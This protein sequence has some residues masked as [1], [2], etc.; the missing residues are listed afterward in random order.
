MK[1]A[2]FSILIILLFITGCREKE[3]FIPEITPNIEHNIV[4]SIKKNN[5]LLEIIPNKNN[6]FFIYKNGK[7]IRLNTKTFVKDAQYQ[8]MFG[9][10]SDIQVFNNII[11][12]NSSDNN[13]SLFD[14][15]KMDVIYSNNNIRF[16]KIKYL[17]GKRIIYLYKNDI[18]VFDYKKNKVLGSLSTKKNNLLNCFSYKNKLYV[19]TAT[20]I[21]EF[22]LNKNKFEIIKLKNKSKSE[23]LYD[24]GFLYYC[25]E[26]RYLIKYSMKNKTVLWANKLPAHSVQK[27]IKLN[28]HIL[29]MLKDFNLYFFNSNGTLYWWEKLGTTPFLKP[30]IS[31]EN[32]IV[33]LLPQKKPTIKF[34][35]I[36]SKK[37][38][39]YKLNIALSKFFIINK[40]LLGLSD[41]SINNVFNLIRIGNVY[42]VDVTILPATVLVKNKSIEFKFTPV[43]LIKPGYNIEIINSEKKKIY[44]LEIKPETKNSFIWFPQEEGDFRLSIEVKSENM[45]KILISKQF[46]VVDMKKLQNN[47]YY[48]ILSECDSVNYNEK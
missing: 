18:I 11:V 41:D 25:S 28:K 10:G 15:E 32:T 20:E 27:P 16:D 5:D 21:N 48:K 23:F 31:E 29:I 40:K 36:K 44:S 2:F 43:N 17:D 12:L 3:L 42:T 9:F 8:C 4:Y 34:F 39:I 24:N 30:L 33:A 14:L 26:K 6:V 1:Q 13:I 19:C 35:N 22:D 38:F 45:D 46:S 37:S 47:Y 7:I